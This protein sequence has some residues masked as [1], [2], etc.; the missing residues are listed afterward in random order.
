[1]AARKTDAASELRKLVAEGKVLL[2]SKRT[3]KLLGKGGI[4]KVFVSQNA[5]SHYKERI[6]SE[7]AASKVELVELSM[8]GE[9]LGTLCK[10]PFSVTVIGVAK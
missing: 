2:G 4:A 10:K 6:A 3:L 1:M 9:E 8:T 7:C 5:P